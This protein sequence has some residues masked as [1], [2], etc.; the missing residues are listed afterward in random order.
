M[1]VAITTM[2]SKGQ[3]VIPHGMRGGFAE[4]D[5]LLL[6]QDDDRLIMKKAS[7]LDEAFREDIEFAKRT[8][9]AWKRHESGKFRRMDAKDFLKELDR[10]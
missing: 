8:E 3:I 6:I 4:G 5:K 7:R 10:W 9:D 2:S 1:D